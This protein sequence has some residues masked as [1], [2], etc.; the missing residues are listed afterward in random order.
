MGIDSRLT[1]IPDFDKLEVVRSGITDVHTWPAGGGEG[2][3]IEH[4]LNF[5]PTPLVFSIVTDG[6]N[7]LNVTPLPTFGIAITDGGGGGVT[8][9]SWFYAY[10]NTTILHISCLNGTGYDVTNQFAW[11]L[12]RNSF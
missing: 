8:F 5:A 9:F 3:Q 4:G 12:L 1:G 11:Y 6:T 2:I 7:I 10:T